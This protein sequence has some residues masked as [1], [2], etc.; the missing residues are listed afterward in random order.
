LGFAFLTAFGCKQAS[1]I[2]RPGA[3]NNNLQGKPEPAGKPR[4]RKSAMTNDIRDGL[5][6]LMF[7]F[8]A[9][10]KITLN[11]QDSYCIDDLLKDPVN[12]ATAQKMRDIGLPND[13]VTQ[14]A[15]DLKSQDKDGIVTAA[16]R[17]TSQRFTDD[18]EIVYGSRPECPSRE[19]L[20]KLVQ[21]ASGK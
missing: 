19:A 21:A 9:T 18:V 12:S 1:S 16:F 17:K 5:N 6:A 3:N 4:E 8:C 11:G 7:M 15:A 10:Q 14:F 13:S 2:G 20:K